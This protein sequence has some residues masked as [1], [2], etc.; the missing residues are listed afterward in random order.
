MKI[1]F[2]NDGLGVGGAEKMMKAIAFGLQSKGHKV[3][4]INLNSRNADLIDNLEGMAVKSANIQYKN[5]I[6]SNYDYVSFTVKSA[7][8]LGSEMVIGFKQLSNFCASVAGKIIG[9]PA[10]ISERADPYR[11]FANARFSVRVK[12]RCINNATGAVFQTKEASEFYSKKLQNRGMV[13]PNP[14]MISGIIPDISYGNMPKNIVSLGRLDNKQ[15]RLDIL[16]KAYTIFHSSHPDYRLLIYGTGEDENLVK[17]FVS[18]SD[19]KDSIELKGLSTNSL[20]DLSSGGMFVISS[21][22]E[23]ISNALLE[24]MAVGLP[25]VSTDHT[26]GGAR[27]LIND[28]ENGLLVP[29]RNPKA[30]ADAM[31]EFADNPELAKKCG[32]NAKNVLNRFSL[33]KIIDKW[34]EYIVS[35][36]A[37]K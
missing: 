15:K 8:E 35:F 29:M 18:E 2:V 6:R 13:I 20:H 21:D 25:V 11:E 37:S 10:I 9:I 28:H 12:L 31:A 34:E 5:A 4:I 3:S 19:S 22:Y 24:A 30:M 32:Q 17:S 7:R 33:N 27:L 36:T 26:P 1:T 16:I 14:I 23:G